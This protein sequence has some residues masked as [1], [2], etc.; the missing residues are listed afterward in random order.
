MAQTVPHNGT[1]PLPSLS[2]V[3]VD[4]IPAYWAD[5]RTAFTGT[6]VFGVGLRDETA[7]TAGLAHLIEHLVMARVGRVN[8]S[9]NASTSDEAI[10]FYAQGAP[11]AVADYLTRVGEAIST[12]DQTTDATVAE[13]RRIISNELGDSDERPGR[14]HL[15]D[16]FG[17]QS[18]GLLDLGTPAHRSHTRDDVLRFA[19][20]WLHAGTAALSF[21]GPIPDG[22]TLRL[23]AARATPPRPEPV[24][25]RRGQWVVNG[26]VPVALSLEL[27]SDD[28]ATTSVASTL[29]SDAL[30]DTLRTEQ[31]LIYSVN[32]EWFPLSAT[33]GLA[34][35]ALDP[36][37]EHALEAASAALAVIRRLAGEGPSP[38]AVSEQQVRLRAADDDPESHTDFLRSRT[39]AVVRG[40]RA[41]DDISA[42]P[43]LDGVTPAAIRDLFAAALDSV[44][45]TFG[46]DLEAESEEQ[47]STALDLK[48][49]EDP[50]PLFPSLSKRELLRHYTQDT[51][52]IFGGKLFSGAR[53]ADLVIDTERVSLVD[54]G[55]FEVRFDDLVLV[56]YSE[57]L[58]VWTLI[59]RQGHLLFVDLDEWRHPKQLHALLGERLP[60]WTQC[61]VDAV[62]AAAPVTV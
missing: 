39:L 57:R 58:R 15:V 22:F 29:L 2:V 27:S 44:F 50:D 16:R 37:P 11:D 26:E 9:H 30:L 3:D 23:P 13:Q 31:H 47:I 54:D 48:P 5:V 53:G 49:A 34:A 59:A 33:H 28:L 25:L 62:P 18:L 20:D 60:G 36:R 4:G 6:L 14:G 55:V 61:E 38:E 24:V 41:R 43:A 7:R 40:R 56:T 46:D 10:S 17:N 52:E 35:Y 1:M 32:G 42:P 51:T 21:T 12:L 8:I 45:V 19:A